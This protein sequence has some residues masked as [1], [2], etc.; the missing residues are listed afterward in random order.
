MAQ[1]PQQQGER[2][3]RHWTCWQHHRRRRDRPLAKDGTCRAFARSGRHHFPAWH[4]RRNEPTAATTETCVTGRRS[5]IVMRP[6][7]I[8]AM[9]WLVA[10]A[11]NDVWMSKAARSS[12][13]ACLHNSSILSTTA[14]PSHRKYFL[15]Q[16]RVAIGWNIFHITLTSLWPQPCFNENSSFTRSSIPAARPEIGAAAG[17]H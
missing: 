14:Q 15:G 5:C 4:R 9:V 2:D 13:C 6:R 8:G 7:A 12:L 16:Q 10:D 1:Y 3:E 11:C 17:R